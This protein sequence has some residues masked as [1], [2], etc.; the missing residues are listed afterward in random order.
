[1]KLSSLPVVLSVLVSPTSFAATNCGN[2]ETAEE[3]A[4]CIVV[5]GSGADY[6][7]WKADWNLRTGGVD[8][9]VAIESDDSSTTLVHHRQDGS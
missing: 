3:V 4:D 1:M 6:A 7:S 9:D 2:Y 8:A 5:E